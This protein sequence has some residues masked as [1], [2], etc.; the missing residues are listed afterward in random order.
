MIT[1]KAIRA[2]RLGLRP[3]GFKQWFNEKMVVE[4]SLANNYCD[5]AVYS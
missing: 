2:S 1:K 4:A 5:P 3:L